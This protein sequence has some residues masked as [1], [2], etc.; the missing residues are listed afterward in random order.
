MNVPTH[1]DVSLVVSPT[2]NSDVSLEVKMPG[3][4][5]ALIMAADYGVPVVRMAVE[6]FENMT[7]ELLGEIEP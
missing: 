6:Q 3:I 1:Y 2:G 4:A 7:S 5:R